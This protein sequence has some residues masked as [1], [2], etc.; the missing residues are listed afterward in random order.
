MT[1]PTCISNAGKGWAT[2]HTHND[3]TALLTFL[4]FSVA[5]HHLVYYYAT[6][7]LTISQL[8]FFTYP[9]FR[10]LNIGATSTFACQ[11]TVIDI[12]AVGDDYKKSA[13][14]ACNANDVDDDSDAST[15]DLLFINACRAAAADDVVADDNNDGVVALNQIAVIFAIRD[16]DDDA[17]CISYSTFAAD[18]TDNNILTNKGLFSVDATGDIHTLLTLLLMVPLG[19]PSFPVCFFFCSVFTALP[20]TSDALM[21]PLCCSSGSLVDGCDDNSVDDMMMAWRMY[22]GMDAINQILLWVDALPS[23]LC[24]LS[25]TSLSLALF[26]FLEPSS[27][28]R[29]IPTSVRPPQ[30]VVCF[31]NSLG[32]YSCLLLLWKSLPLQF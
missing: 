5:K 28:W 2:F 20:Y 25:F 4:L 16:D 29:F 15:V 30:T 10:Y 8:H 23:S 3:T 13:V 1:A 31:T 9:L 7:V 19:F 6:T 12:P 14:D 22:V 18:V 26:H 11:P 27:I 17:V 24:S 32:C 21:D